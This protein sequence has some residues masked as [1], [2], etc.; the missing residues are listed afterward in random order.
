MSV[1]CGAA[2][3]CVGP[4]GCGKTTALNKIFGVNPTPRDELK[5]PKQGVTAVFVELNENA[6]PK[7]CDLAIE[8][9]QRF[10]QV[11]LM[12][13]LPFLQGLVGGVPSCLRIYSDLRKRLKEPGEYIFLTK[14]NV[15]ESDFPRSWRNEFL[16]FDLGQLK[17]Q[18]IEEKKQIVLRD[19]FPLLAPP[20]T[21][22][23]FGY[24]ARCNDGGS[25]HLDQKDV[26]HEVGQRWT[27]CRMKGGLH[28]LLCMYGHAES[29]TTRRIAKQALS[30][31]FSGMSLM[32][33]GHS[34][35]LSL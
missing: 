15:A 16:T 1:K 5:L 20:L 21:T 6:S 27:N 2:Y 8:T 23:D 34:F 35:E 29:S 10:D 33:T 14:S 17:A 19:T 31:I 30:A 26:L 25:W 7:D 22:L 11:H 12:L 32:C 28:P 3:I 13:F 4:E 18:W 9:A 24:G